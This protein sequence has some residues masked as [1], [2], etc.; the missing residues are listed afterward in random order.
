MITDIKATLKDM[1]KVKLDL[2]CVVSVYLD[3]TPDAKGQRRIGPYLKKE[4]QRIE[5]GMPPHGPLAEALRQD[6]KI[7]NEY[8]ASKLESRTKGVAIF[9]SQTKGFFEV[10][11]TGFPFP[12]TVVMAKLPYLYPLVRLADDYAR[13]GVLICD[14]HR[15]RL[16]TVNLGQVEDEHDIISDT[17]S[18]PTKGYETKKGQM[19]WADGRHQRYHREQ[20]ARHLR[21]VAGQARRY[22]GNNRAAIVILAAENG[23][24][25]ELKALLAPGIRAAQVV[26]GAFELRTPTAKVLEQSMRLFKA[27]ENEGSLEIAA[28]VA[29]LARSKGG[30]AVAGTDPVLGSLMQDRVETLVIDESYDGQGWQCDNCLRLGTGGKVT[31]CPYCNSGDINDGPDMKEALVQMAVRMG[32]KVEFVEGSKLLRASGG[33]GALLRT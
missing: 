1:M 26:A 7:I 29:T 11:Q 17:A 4:F 16:L 2:G 18:A 30:R 23:V 33:V 27:K 19:G 15:A 14:E 25:A 5:H 32:A 9:M 8:V 21:E 28:K 24:Q 13:Y 12:N 3:A 22:F 6:F 10:L 31:R 20:V